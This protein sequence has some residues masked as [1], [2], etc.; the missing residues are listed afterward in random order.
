MLAGF[1]HPSRF[2]ALIN[3]KVVHDT[4][5]TVTDMERIAAARFRIFGLSQYP[6]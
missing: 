1:R 4:A 3:A 5:R 6:A 2:S